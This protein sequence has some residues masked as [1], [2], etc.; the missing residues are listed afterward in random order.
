MKKTTGA[1]G[2]INPE[3]SRHVRVMSSHWKWKAIWLRPYFGS[4][5]PRDLVSL[6]FFPAVGYN[7]WPCR[8]GAAECL[9]IYWC[10]AQGRRVEKEVKCCRAWSLG[11]RRRR[12][13]VRGSLSARSLTRFH[14]R[15]FHSR[16]PQWVSD[17]VSSSQS[18]PSS[19]QRMFL[20]TA[21]SV[22][23][24]SPLQSSVKQDADWVSLLRCPAWPSPSEWPIDCWAQVALSPSRPAQV[25]GGKMSPIYS[26]M[27]V[28]SSD[29]VSHSFNSWGQ[30]CLCSKASV[31]QWPHEL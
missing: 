27:A 5:S 31:S 14:P 7:Y 3:A 2:P 10:P 19:S 6:F 13:A 1:E 12:R 4:S 11:R 22:S 28:N 18:S 29:F 24:R 26:L 25:T 9:F 16:W 30:Q 23:P 21:S 15:I 20:L 8:E 17:L